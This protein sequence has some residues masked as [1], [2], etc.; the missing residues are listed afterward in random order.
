MVPCLIEFKD[1]NI[2]LHEGNDKIYQWIQWRNSLGTPSAYPT[3]GLPPAA[4]QP[5]MVAPPP[6]HPQFTEHLASPPP[7]PQQYPQHQPAMVAPPPQHPQFT[8]QPS[9]STL[10]GDE[11]KFEFTGVKAEEMNA[12]QGIPSASGGGG[13]GMAYQG[14]PLSAIQPEPLVSGPQYGQQIQ[15]LGQQAD[16]H[17]A[18]MAKGKVSVNEVL[19]R[20]A[21]EREEMEEEERKRPR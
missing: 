1:N 16:Q 18:S 10:L 7:P 14:T 4:H 12:A 13:T 11:I 21:K 9:P 8:A 6:Q 20:A 3:T 17:Y 19:Q 15:A 5:A 2:L